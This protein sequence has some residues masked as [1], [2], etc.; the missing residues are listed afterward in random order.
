MIALPTDLE[1]TRQ[2]V[3]VREAVLAATLSVRSPR[4]S[5]RFRVTRNL[6]IA[7]AAIAALTAGSLIV[8]RLSQN[9]IDHSAICFQHASLDS[10]QVPISGAGDTTDEPLDPIRGCAFAWKLG[11]FEPGGPPDPSTANFPVP[12]LTACTLADGSAGVFPREGR[13]AEDFCA[14]LGLAVWDS[15]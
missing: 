14:A 1:I 6:I 5:T 10:Y 13:P 15:D 9:D 2:L 7:A 8:A 3:P 11:N 4:R 12:E